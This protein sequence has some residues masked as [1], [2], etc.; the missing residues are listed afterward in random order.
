M[1]V[2]RY[3]RAAIFY[4]EVVLNNKNFVAFVESK[5]LVKMSRKSFG[6][7][8][9]YLSIFIVYWESL[10]FLYC[11]DINVTKIALVIS[12]TLYL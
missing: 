3:E 8:D 5:V 9:C 1:T 10:R 12:V 2:L 7:S 6:E 4:S 11:C